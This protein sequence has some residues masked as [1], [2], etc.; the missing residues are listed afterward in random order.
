MEEEDKEKEQTSQVAESEDVNLGHD[1][2]GCVPTAREDTGTR[3]KTLPANYA[4]DEDDWFK[5]PEDPLFRT[6]PVL[7]EVEMEL[8]YLGEESMHCVMSDEY[9]FD[10]IWTYASPSLRI[11]LRD[12]N[13]DDSQE[14]LISRVVRHHDWLVSQR[15]LVVREQIRSSLQQG[16]R[17]PLMAEVIA[18][19]RF[20][21]LDRR[22]C[23][24]VPSRKPSGRVGIQGSLFKYR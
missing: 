12:L 3:G 21:A 15:F 1:S 24:H 4:G 22:Q 17:H 16:K 13:H 20:V 23:E 10:F 8:L 6:D 2:D 19:I 11:K 14:T 5:V 9:S 7:N 18:Q